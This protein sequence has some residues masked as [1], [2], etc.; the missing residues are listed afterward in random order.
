MKYEDLI[1]EKRG[2]VAVVTL[3]R[4]H[5]LNALAKRTRYELAHVLGEIEA[6]VSVGALVIT[7]APRPDGRPAFCSGDDLKEVADQPE[8]SAAEKATTAVAVLAGRSYGNDEADISRRLETMPKPS[9]AAIDGV[10][11][12]GGIQLALSCDI[13]LVAE[14][15]QLSDLEVTNLGEMGTAGGGVRL[16]RIVGPAWAKRLVL[17]GETIDGSLAVRIG[18]A[19]EVFPPD[20]L[21]DGAVALAARIARRRPEALATAKAI[22]DASVGTDLERA[23]R[24]GYLGSAPIANP[25]GPKAFAEKRPPP[26]LRPE[27]DPD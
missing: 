24:Y 7:G 14:T 3:N 2:R 21:L 10:C 1:Y 27:D 20:S 8:M 4:P 26:H 6:D 25:E 12:A 5:R 16:A 13:R 22:I 11:T 23:L 15:A 17:S 9:I 19:Q 18:L